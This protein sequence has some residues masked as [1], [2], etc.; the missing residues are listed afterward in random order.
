MSA[1]IC[2]TLSAT[3]ALVASVATESSGLSQVMPLVDLH[4]GSHCED[5][6]RCS[7]DSYDVEHDGNFEDESVHSQSGGFAGVATD[8]EQNDD[9]SSEYDAFLRDMAGGSFQCVDSDDDDDDDGDDDEDDASEASDVCLIHVDAAPTEP[10]RDQGVTEPATPEQAPLSP[11]EHESPLSDGCPLTYDIASLPTSG[12][13]FPQGGRTPMRGPSQGLSLAFVS[14]SITAM[15][16]MG[17]G[18]HVHVAGSQQ[19]LCT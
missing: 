11:V 8:N 15:R 10:L 12:S 2:P 5:L 1:A 19:A 6:C 16:H 18:Y 13:I 4:E 7:F 3:I 17:C 14:C 9:A